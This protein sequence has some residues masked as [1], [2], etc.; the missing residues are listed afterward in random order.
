MNQRFLTSSGG[1]AVLIAVTC[2]PPVPII[3]QAGSSSAAAE[4]WTLPRMADGQPD[5]QGVWDFGTLTPLER[6][7]SHG[8]KEFLTDEDAAIFDREKNR[9]LNRDLIDPKKGGLNSPP[10][11]VVPYNEFWFERGNKGVKS[12]R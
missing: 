1:L 3:G 11:G 10:G 9:S 6:P 5:L 4:T 7:R 8:A 12:K 2:L